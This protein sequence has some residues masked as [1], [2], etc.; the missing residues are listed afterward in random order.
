MSDPTPPPDDR[1]LGEPI[2]ELAVLAETPENGFLDRIRRGILRR[3][4]GVQFLEFAFEHVLG[5]LREIGEL[6]FGA[7]DPASRKDEPE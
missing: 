3:I 7:M 6:I 2:A 1:D 4:A 5:F